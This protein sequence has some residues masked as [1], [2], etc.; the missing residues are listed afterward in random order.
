MSNSNIA[1]TRTKNPGEVV[2]IPVN[3]AERL[4]AVTISASSWDSSSVDL[5]ATVST[6]TD[7][8]TIVRVS[9]GVAGQTYF[10]QNTVTTDD[11][12]TLFCYV[13]IIIET[14]LVA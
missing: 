9:G 12:Q 3:W 1:G 11:G 8:Q 2:D 14:D 13:R 10:L 6:F 4:G 7:Q 5:T